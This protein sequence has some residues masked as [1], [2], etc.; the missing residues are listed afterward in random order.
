MFL[1]GAYILVTLVAM[2]WIASDSGTTGVR[3]LFRRDLHVIAREMDVYWSWMLTHVCRT[4]VLLSLIAF[5]AE[6]AYQQSG[7]DRDQRGTV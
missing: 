5:N 7:M 2:T 3:E 1:L 6:L 4:A